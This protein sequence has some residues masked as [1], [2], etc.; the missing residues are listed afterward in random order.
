M[1]TTVKKD[2]YNVAQGTLTYQKNDKKCLKDYRAKKPG[3]KTCVHRS[4]KKLIHKM[5]YD[6]SKRRRDARGR[7]VKKA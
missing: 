4:Q 7:F 3:S 2:K 6:E 5:N 1:A